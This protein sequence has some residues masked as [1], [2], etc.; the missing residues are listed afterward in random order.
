[1]NQ[2]H[3]SDFTYHKDAKG[4][5]ALIAEMSDEVMRDITLGDFVQR[6]VY[7]FSPAR[8]NKPARTVHFTFSRFEYYGEGADR[9]LAAVHLYNYETETKMVIFND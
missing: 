7:V 3:I 6:G 4:A 1:M 5:K 8:E 2:I 9:E